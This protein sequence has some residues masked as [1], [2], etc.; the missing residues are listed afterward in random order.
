MDKFLSWLPNSRAPNFIGAPDQTRKK[1]VVKTK[2]YPANISTLDKRCY[3]IMDQCWKILDPTFKMKQNPTSVF[4]VAE[5]RYN[6]G[7]RRWNNVKS[8]LHNVD[9]I[10]FQRWQTSFQRWCSISTL[11]QYGFDVSISKPICLVKSTDLQKD[12]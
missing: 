9:A 11:F 1:W 3:S 2:A 7:V 10:A 6:V 5:R 12:L 8:T 4:I